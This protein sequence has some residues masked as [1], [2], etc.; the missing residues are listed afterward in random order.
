[1]SRVFMEENYPYAMNLYDNEAMLALSQEMEEYLSSRGDIYEKDEGQNNRFHVIDKL[2]KIMVEWAGTIGKAKG[3]ESTICENGGGIHLR[4][5]GSTR[6]GVHTPDADIDVLCVAPSF[7]DRSD[8][9]G[10]FCMNMR[11]RVDVSML[12]AVP[13]AYTPVVKFN[14]DGQAV[15]MIFVSL[16]TLSIPSDLDILDSRHL[17]GLNEQG[18]PN[19]DE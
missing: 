17:H 18:K 19:P 7:V 16:S 4:I 3:I 9:F 15:D 12:S 2:T 1:M 13:E 8:F 6:L 10:S 14:I 5:F 11:N